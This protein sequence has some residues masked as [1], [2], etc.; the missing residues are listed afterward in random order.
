MMLK[1]TPEMI[2]AAYSYLCTS[3]PFSGWNLP[4]PDDVT[5]RVSRRPGEFGRYQ[6]IGGR[7]T[8]A[9][10]GASIG[11]TSTLMRYLAHECVHMHLEITGMESR[12]G[13]PNTHNA[14][15]RKFAAQVSK[16]H[17]FDPKA[18]Y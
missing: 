4:D 6:L 15:F 9:M 13:G 18:F 14:A 12:S 17:G 10:S 16:V 7:H 3:E 5:F 11:Q 1:L 2:A 8:I